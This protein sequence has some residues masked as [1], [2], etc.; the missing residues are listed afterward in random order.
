VA[1]IR[2]F[3]RE[4]LESE[5]HD[6]LFWDIYP[7]EAI[8][9][10]PFGSS[11]AIIQPGGRTMLHSH[12]PAETFVICRGNGTIS[13]DG[14]SET[15]TTGDVIYLPPQSVHDLRN[16]STTEDLAFVSV[17]WKARAAER[18]TPRFLVPSP[19]TPNGPLHLGHLAGPYLCADVKRRYYRMHG[20]DATLACLT[21]DH[22]SY[23]VSRAQDD[24]VSPADAAASFSS[25]IVA[26]LAAFG[27][28][29]D[30]AIAPSRDEGYRAAVRERF[31]RLVTE[32]KVCLRDIDALW[33]EACDAGVHDVWLSGTCPHCKTEMYGAFCDACSSPCDAAELVDPRCDRCNG[34]PVRRTS[35]RFVFPIRPYAEVLADYHRRSRLSPK[36]RRLAAKWIERD[37]AI[38]ASEPGTW[39]IAADGIDGHIISPWFEVSLAGSYLRDTHAPGSDVSC[40]F[41]Y[42]NAFLYLVQDPAV[43]VA[44]DA[45]SAMPHELAANEFLLRDQEKMSTSRARTLD[46]K[47]LLQRIPSDLLRLYLAKV[48]PEDEPAMANV[49]IAQ[50][51]LSTVTRYYQRWLARLGASIAMEA[52]G[53]APAASNPSL[54]P[55]SHEQ[56]QFFDDLAA[57]VARARR[58][59]DA[60][61]LRTVASTIHELVE[62]A[63]AFGTAQGHLAGIPTLVSQ[64]GTGL[65]LELAA[66]RTFAMIAAPIMPDLA[67]RLA[68]CLGETDA[69]AWSDTIVMVPPGS[70]IALADIA[71]FPQ[72]IDLVGGEHG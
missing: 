30:F 25:D 40:F 2:K 8:E 38:T 15:V 49:E 58:G 7:W 72:T 70:S 54:A 11:L 71:F 26:T 62:R 66:V 6:V 42:D 23:V 63:T 14:T 16:D 57:F 67:A 46:A 53:R 36:L 45:A 55:W 32:G 20:I 33:C 19:K 69:L 9:D 4:V 24:K 3:S 51:F 13:I 65:A 17:F 28:A 52:G 37:F 29:P 56:R 22:Q 48:R 41:G 1:T 59:Y 47:E 68:T 44:L 27:A 5:P 12:D 43:C 64:R 18:Q 35:R 50:M 34:V 31:A 39:G 21:D 61:S 60:C 10:T